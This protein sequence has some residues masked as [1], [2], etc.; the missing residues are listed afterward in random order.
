MFLLNFL[1]YLFVL[2]YLRLA[3]FSFKYFHFPI[4]QYLLASRVEDTTM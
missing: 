3:I 2:F 4:L 1:I